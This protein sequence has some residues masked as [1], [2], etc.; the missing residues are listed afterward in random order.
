MTR[1][2]DTLDLA[3]LQLRSGEGRRFEQDITIEPLQLGADSYAVVPREVPALVDVSRMTGGGWSLRL[4]FTAEVEGQCMRCLGEASPSFSIDAREI[5]QADAG[6][7]LDSPYVTAELVDLGAWARDAL[8]LALPAQVLCT[9]ECAGLCPECGERL[10]DLPPDHVHER[11]VDPRWA[12][13]GELR[14][15]AGA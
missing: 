13:L 4:R 11:P 15:D 6:P 7:E 3:S 12:K 2:P 1:R 9:P 8:L 14:F 5:E 10:A